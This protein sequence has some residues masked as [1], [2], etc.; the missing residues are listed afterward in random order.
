MNSDNYQKAGQIR[1]RIHLWTEYRNNTEEGINSRADKTVGYGDIES[2]IRKQKLDIA[3]ELIE[4]L[5]KRV[6]QEIAQ[7]EL[8]FTKL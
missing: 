6:D 3:N 2:P 1:S 4:K 8:E 5:N 7:L